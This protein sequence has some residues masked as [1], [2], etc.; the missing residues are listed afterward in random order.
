MNSQQP[1]VRLTV[2]DAAGHL[3]DVS[4]TDGGPRRPRGGRPGLTSSLGRLL[5][6]RSAIRDLPWMWSL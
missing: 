5:I 1:R 6:S 4:I 3:Y 2:E